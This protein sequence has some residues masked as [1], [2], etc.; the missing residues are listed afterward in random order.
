[1]IHT[2][3]FRLILAGVCFG[4][5][6][7]LVN[8]FASKPEETP[9]KT[10]SGKDVTAK[11]AS[12]IVAGGCFWCVETDF[13]KAPGVIDV[14]SGYSG[15]RTQNPTYK[16]YAAGGHR[17][18][19]MVVY[20]PSEITYAG[21]VEWLV[22]H[23]DP[24]N[25]RGQFNDKGIQYSP[26]IYFANE[27]E[28]AEAERVLGAIEDMKVYRGKLNV[29]VEPRAAFWPAE[30]YHQD[31]HHKN[32]IKYNF[33]RLGSGRDAFVQSYWGA[34]AHVLELPGSLPE[35][36]K[37][38][39]DPVEDVANKEKRPWESFTKPSPAELRRKLSSIQYKVTQQEGTEPHHANAYWDNKRVGL[40][41]DVVSGAP[42][43]SSSAKYDSGT[44]WPSFVEPITPDAVEYKVDRSLFSVRTEVRSHYGDSHLGHVF[45]DGPVDRGGKRYCMNSASLRFIPKEKMEEEGYGE[46]LDKVK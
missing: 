46:Y 36:A 37:H 15:G 20:D 45:N 6:V 39:S 44:G 38:E 43:F 25:G 22:K 18:V 32:S 16:T 3:R 34:R 10:S 27:E 13:E 7:W 11:H 14:I 29:A 12:A 33:F 17:E 4:S 21:I 23:I 30:E 24:T 19:A 8:V 42:L 31:Y 9:T 2:A 41:V 40:Y 26:A 1:M 28:K 35:S 5:A